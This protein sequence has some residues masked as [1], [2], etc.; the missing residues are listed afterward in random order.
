MTAELVK[1][2]LETTLLALD[3]AGKLRRFEGD[4]LTQEIE[5]SFETGRMCARMTITC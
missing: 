5:L 1:A 2:G 3:R 4:E